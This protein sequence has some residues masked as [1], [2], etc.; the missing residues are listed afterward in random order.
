M[1]KVLYARILD[2][3]VRSLDDAEFPVDQQSNTISSASILLSI[4][5]V[6]KEQVG[7]FL[8]LL[9]YRSYQNVFCAGFCHFQR[10]NAE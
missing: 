7:D 1:C 6:I 10:Q 5:C 9:A 8:P 4:Y 2:G 3:S